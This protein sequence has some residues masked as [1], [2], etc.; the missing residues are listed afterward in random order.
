MEKCIIVDKADL[1]RESVGLLVHLGT[2]KDFEQLQKELT[3]KFKLSHD[4]YRK[5]FELLK[6]IEKDAKAEFKN[7]EGELEYYFGKENSDGSNIG[8]VAILWT[9]ILYRN[10]KSLKEYR[11][12]LDKLSE[13]EYCEKFGNA[14]AC[15]NSI[16]QSGEDFQSYTEPIQVIRILMQMEI[17]DE[18]KWKLQQIF[19][20]KEEHWNRIFALLKKAEK[21]LLPYE[22]E[23]NELA[24]IFA[25]CYQKIL[26]DVTIKEL[27]KNAIDVTLD[28]N[29][30]GTVVIPSFLLPNYF[31]IMADGKEKIDTPYYLTVGILFDDKFSISMTSLKEKE[32]GSE[33]MAKVLKLLSD[34]SKLEILSYIKNKK[35]YGSE[36][37]KQLNLTNATVSHHMSGLVN[38]GLV[39]MEKEDTKIYYRTNI[40]EISEVLNSCL[41]YLTE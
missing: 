16:L 25:A 40:E 36:L 5:K 1:V 28:D 33:Y 12:Q 9:D 10:H 11:E 21:V 39:I 15:Y 4:L 31:S 29:E 23:M 3:K 6:Q 14:L 35:A 32:E 34:R 20:N 26:N 7:D 8:E 38:A 2:K 19:L 17:P 30:Q 22:E 37:A 41:K 18:T 13:K 24:K 27:V